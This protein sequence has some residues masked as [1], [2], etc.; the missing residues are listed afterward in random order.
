MCV[1][2]G[3]VWTLEPTALDVR[4]RPKNDIIA[5]WVEVEENEGGCAASAGPLSAR[6]RDRGLDGPA[7]AGEA[8]VVCTQQRQ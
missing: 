5:S 4:T 1:W 8:L 6:L 3:G 7:M 2:E